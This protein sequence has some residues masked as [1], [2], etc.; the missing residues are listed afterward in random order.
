MLIFPPLSSAHSF[1]FSFYNQL[2]LFTASA[3]LLWHVS[4]DSQHQHS[5][6]SCLLRIWSCCSK[7]TERLL[8]EYPNEKFTYKRRNDMLGTI[9]IVVVILML[10]GAMPRSEERRVGKECR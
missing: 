8:E 9:L 3:D 1:H 2:I 4:C 6:L 5:V 7:E 10:L